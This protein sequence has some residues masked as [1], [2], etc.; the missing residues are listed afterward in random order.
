M[1]IRTLPGRSRP[2]TPMWTSNIRRI[3]QPVAASAIIFTG[4]VLERFSAVKTA[5]SGWMRRKTMK[6]NV[7]VLEAAKRLEA[8]KIK[9][10]KGNPHLA[11]DIET[12]L[13]YVRETM[14][15]DK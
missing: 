1:S 3:A 6:R 5:W 13:R 4:I 14:E 9:M 15:E 8:Y 11:A 2:V 10:L 7:K 12:V